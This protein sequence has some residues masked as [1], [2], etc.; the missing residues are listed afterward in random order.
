[1]NYKTYEPKPSKLICFQMRTKIL[2]ARVITIKGDGNMRHLCRVIPGENKTAQQ[3]FSYN[4][5]S[6]F[7]GK[8]HECIVYDFPLNSAVIGIIIRQG[9]TLA[10]KLNQTRH[11][12]IFYRA[13]R[14]ETTQSK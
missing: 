14:K 2:M 6:V 1:M 4:F 9:I 11:K 8:L 5:E 13:Y 3:S 10:I 12:N 7:S